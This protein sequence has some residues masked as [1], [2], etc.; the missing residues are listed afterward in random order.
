MAYS[1]ILITIALFLTTSV[2][3][4]TNSGTNCA[5]WVANGFCKSPYYT[6]SQKVAYCAL[7]CGYCTSSTS[8]T[9]ST[10]TGSSSCTNSASAC[11]SWAANGFCSSTFYTTAQKTAYC[12]S[13]CGLC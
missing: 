9:T 12:A 8:S 13:S 4:C 11:S 5:N 1:I 3:S 10:T 2:E 6:Y 7:S